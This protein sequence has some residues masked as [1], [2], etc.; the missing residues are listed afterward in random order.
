MINNYQPKKLEKNPTIDNRNIIIL[1][2]NLKFKNIPCMI[3]QY[4]KDINR[5][6]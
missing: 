5:F 2:N 6:N 4:N 1:E 3:E